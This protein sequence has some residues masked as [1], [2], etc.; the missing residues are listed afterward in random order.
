MI[1]WLRTL[2][3]I[4]LFP[5]FFAYHWAALKEWIP[6]VLGGYVNEMSALV[7]VGFV[8]AWLISLLLVRRLTVRWTVVDTGFALFMA[9]FAITILLHIVVAKTLGVTKSHIASW[10]QLLACYLAI[11]H[12]SL[13]LVRT[14]LLWMAALFSAAVLWAAQTDLLGLLL[15]SS[16][17]SSTATYA[18]LARALLIT[19]VFGIGGQ[20]SRLLRCSSWAVMLFVLFLIGA[21]S[22]IVGAVI[23]FGVLEI[24]AS[25]RPMHVALLV[26]VSIVLSAIVV[27]GELDTLFQFFPDNRFLALLLEGSGDASSAERAL[28]QELAWRAVLDSPILGDYGHY[29]R[30]V[31]AG[32]YAHNWLSAWVDLGLVGLLLFIVLHVMAAWS[33]MFVYRTAAASSDVTRMLQSA[34]GIGL[35]TMVTVFNLMSKSFADTGLATA[36][37][38]LAALLAAHPVRRRMTAP[39]ERV[40]WPSPGQQDSPG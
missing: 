23:L 14:P 31:S 5:G 36:T 26:V 25:R 24:V 29:E 17:K 11:R 22:E 16:D 12:V 10:V 28:F 2:P 35:L 18:D 27:L 30:E 4:A 8:I 33:A 6:P 19:A 40:P 20:K 34:M 3:F 1:A 38:L 21:R 37:A 32:A 9:W 7:C 15:L 39:R 13:E